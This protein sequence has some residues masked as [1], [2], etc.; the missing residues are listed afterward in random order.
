M[1][2]KDHARTQAETHPAST[3]SNVPRTVLLVI[4]DAIVFLVFAFIGIRSHKEAV[5]AVKVVTTAAPFALGWFL[6]APFVGAFSRK[7]T[8]APGKMTLYTILAW[9]PSLVLGMTFRGIT[10][11]HQ[12]PPPSFMVVT[13]VTNT[14]FL[15]VWRV[16][17]AWLTRKKK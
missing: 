8:D 2:I 14:L 12:V 16:P 13:L 15:L 3:S 5:D 10:V 7:K 1:A 11:D 17:F 4:G 9:L 6:V